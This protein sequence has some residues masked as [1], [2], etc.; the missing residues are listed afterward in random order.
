M[1]GLE[2]FQKVLT[3]IFIV[4]VIIFYPGHVQAKDGDEQSQIILLNDAASAL[5]D[6]NPGFS[7]S[8]TKLADDKEKEWNAKNSNKNVP[9]N[10]LADKNNTKSQEQIELLKAAALAIQPTYPLIA[11]GLDKMAKDMDRTIEIEK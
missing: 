6:I 11:E 7:K 8:L 3:N 1:K 5:E 2:L 9:S 4:F 10:S